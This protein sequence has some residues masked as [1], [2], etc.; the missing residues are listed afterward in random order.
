[1]NL[2]SKKTISAKLLKCGINRIWFDP[3]EN[4]KIA[5]A[6]TNQD[7]QKLINEK[8]IQKKQ[9]KGVSRARANIKLT[10]KKKGL[11]KSAGNRKGKA[12]ARQGRKARWIK[13]I[14]AVRREL[15]VLRAKG[16]FNKGEYR[17]M[18]RLGCGGV[19]KSRAYT[20]MYAKKFIKKQ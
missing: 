20:R 13:Q 7:I 14:R 11:Q 12:G 5:K 17:K 6:L 2:R 8:I 9:K 18:Y 4:D 15:L 19:L 10:Q 16:I 3:E 1:M